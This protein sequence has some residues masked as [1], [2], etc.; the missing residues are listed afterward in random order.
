MG[1]KTDKETGG[2][3][4]TDIRSFV[5]TAVVLSLG[6]AFLV[7]LWSGGLGG[8]I[9]RAGD[10]LAWFIELAGSLGDRFAQIGS[11]VPR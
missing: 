2:G 3:L 11:G 5:Y 1:L 9:E 4:L 6:L 7:T 8:V 10:G